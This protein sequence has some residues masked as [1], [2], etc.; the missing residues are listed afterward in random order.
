MIGTFTTSF[1]IVHAAGINVN[2]DASTSF[3]ILEE[4]IT[5]AEGYV[6]IA[7]QYDWVANSAAISANFLGA[8]TLATK[9]LAAIDLIRYDE[10]AIGKAEAE[11]RINV[12][13]DRV[14]KVIRF[15][16]DDNRRTLA[17]AS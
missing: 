1:A 3:A 13:N 7:T 9:N 15:L 12:L 14:V 11:S 8:L 5:D 10:G 4:F 6:N 17:G 2:S 16:D